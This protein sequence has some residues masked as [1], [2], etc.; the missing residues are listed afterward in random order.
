[1]TED[2]KYCID[3]M[4]EHFNKELVITKKM[5]KLLRTLLNVR[6]VIIFMLMVILK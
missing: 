6:F 4:K 1:M 5:M 3:A 2:S